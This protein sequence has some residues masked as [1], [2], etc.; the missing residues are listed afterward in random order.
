MPSRFEPCGI[1]QMYGQRYGTLPIAFRTGGL[2]DTIVDLD[3]EP[4]RGSGILEENGTAGGLV[5]AVARGLRAIASDEWDSVRFRI[6]SLPVGWGGPVQ[7]Y[8]QM[9]KQTMQARRA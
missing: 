3:A 4:V 7:R 9:Y 1:V 8:V 5:S 2:A 6:M